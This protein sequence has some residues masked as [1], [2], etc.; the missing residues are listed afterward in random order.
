MG[1]VYSDVLHTYSTYG[2]ND[3]AP[4]LG[5][6]TSD[7]RLANFRANIEQLETKERTFYG[8]ILGKPVSSFAEFLAEVRTSL[9]NFEQDSSA[10]RALDND[11]LTQALYRKYGFSTK[12]QWDQDAT[13]SRLVVKLDTSV[14]EDTLNTYIK[15][16][17]K[18]V[19]VELQKIGQIGKNDLKLSVSGNTKAGTLTIDFGLNKSAIE[20]KLDEIGLL[21]GVVNAAMGRKLKVE[22]QS[23]EWFKSQILNDPDL[24]SLTTNKKEFVWE[25]NSKLRTKD[26]EGNAN[27]FAISKSGLSKKSKSQQKQIEKEIKAF[28]K[29]TIGYNQTSKVF[30]SVFEDAWTSQISSKNLGIAGYTWNGA[31]ANIVGA[32]GEFQTYVLFKYISHSFGNRSQGVIADAFA[33]GEQ[34]KADVQFF[35]NFGIQVKNYSGYGSGLKELK[36][37]IHP[38]KLIQY[39]Q[40]NEWIGSSFSEYIANYYFNKDVNRA[41]FSM[42]VEGLKSA[43]AEIASMGT[44]KVAI[45]DTVC[46]YNLGGG[47]LIPASELL[48]EVYSL[49][50]KLDTTQVS[51]TSAFE[52]STDKEFHKAR[53]KKG[54]KKEPDFLTYWERN[55]DSWKPKP[56]NKVLYSQMLNSKISIRAAVPYAQFLRDGYKL[57]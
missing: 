15:D 7:K 33:G 11:R 16:V 32:F 45:P 47:Y 19:I 54:N 10:L 28:I 18:A 43:F 42:I 17:E 22:A 57:W 3:Y 37:N 27:P 13:F 4:H 44:T 56:A 31:I 46:L 29:E 39:P 24:I 51:I 14:A 20:K 12:G 49:S 52:G 34:L 26:K 9:G 50:D 6:Y 38:N 23:L 35:K 36:F 25:A 30:Q 2:P 48:K 41:P 53:E 21:K 5:D 1:S 40:V 55:G 8:A